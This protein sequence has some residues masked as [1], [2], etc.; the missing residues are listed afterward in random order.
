M[1]ASSANPA[2]VMAEYAKSGRS[3]CKKCEK[4][5]KA[6]ALRLGLVSKDMRRGFDVTKWFHFECFKDGVELV[7]SVDKINGFASLKVC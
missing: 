7:T 4:N 1:M 6:K 3:S 5:I 2:K